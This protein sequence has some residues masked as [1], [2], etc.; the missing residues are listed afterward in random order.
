MYFLKHKDPT[1]F[2]LTNKFLE[3]LCLNSQKDLVGIFAPKGSNILKAGS[4]VMI[5]LTHLPQKLTQKFES[6][7]KYKDAEEPWVLLTHRASHLRNHPNEV[8]FPGGKIEPD[9]TVEE[10]N[11]SLILKCIIINIKFLSANFLCVSIEFLGGFTRNR[12]RN[13]IRPKKN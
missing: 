7:N 5:L 11:L 4:S 1:Y 12:R 2:S 6:I 13:W 8:S 10:V 9:E 3:N